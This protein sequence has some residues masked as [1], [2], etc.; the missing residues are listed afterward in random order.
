MGQEAE[1]YKRYLDGD[2]EGIVLLIRDCKDG[3]I[4]YLY[5]RQVIIQYIRQEI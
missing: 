4:L 3:L 2:D 5:G 1:Y